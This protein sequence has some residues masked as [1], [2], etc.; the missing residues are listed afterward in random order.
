MNGDEYVDALEVLRD[1]D[2]SKL[3]ALSVAISGFPFEK[4]N[5]VERYWITNAID[6]GSL[7]TVKWMISK[8]VELNFRDDEGYTPLHNS[9]DRTL[10]NKYKILEL[11]V[12]A[13]ADVNAHGTNDWTP[14][15][16]A[17]VREDQRAMKILLQAVADRTIRTRID[18]YA[19]PEEEAKNLGKNKSV[20]FLANFGNS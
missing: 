2:E 17:A 15:H 3:E 4:D 11:L 5:F 9:I 14:L 6:C 16:M 20:E 10:P 7:E 12:Q 13:G 19:T 8:G 18:S 1:T